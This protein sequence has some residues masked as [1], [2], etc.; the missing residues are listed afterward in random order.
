MLYSVILSRQAA[1]SVILVKIMLCMIYRSPK[2][3]QTYLYLAKKDDFSCVPSALMQTFGKPIF[4][5][6]LALE[7]RKKLAGADIEKVRSELA[8]KGYYL[9]LPPP[10][11]NI[12]NTHLEQQNNASSLAP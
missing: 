3:D 5:M 2:R 9:Q 11:E 12:L 4:S 1:N 8:E 6:V 10:A 7:R